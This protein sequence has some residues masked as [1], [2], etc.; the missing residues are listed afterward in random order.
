MARLSAALLARPGAALLR[1][2]WEDHH[3]HRP[4]SQQFTLAARA[5]AAGRTR[6]ALRDRPLSAP[7]GHARAG[8]VARHPSAR[9]IARHHRQ[10][11]HHRG[12]RRD[13]R[14]H[15]RY[16]W[17]GPPDPA[18]EHAGTAALHLLAALCGRL[19][20]AAAA[21]EAAVHVDAEARAGVAAPAGAQGFQPGPDRRWSIRSSSS[22]WRIGKANSARTNGSPATT[23]PPPTSR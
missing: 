1:H 22:I 20:D 14:I 15:Y 7:A 5:L 3:A 8:G 4:S 23:S 11:Q 17:R 18:A 6:C 21:A 9:K 13:R 12:V 10:R 16:L 2:A 19:R